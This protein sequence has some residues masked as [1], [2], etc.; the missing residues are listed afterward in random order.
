MYYRKGDC[1][2]VM[3]YGTGGIGHALVSHTLVL[4]TIR[5]SSGDRV[6]AGS[7]GRNEPSSFALWSAQSSRMSGLWRNWLRLLKASGGK[8]GHSFT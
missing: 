3:I 1:F 4:T 5:T 8:K 2:L 6:I 7:T